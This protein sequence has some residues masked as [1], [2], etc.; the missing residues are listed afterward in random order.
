MNKCDFNACFT[1][2]SSLSDV[3]D[4]MTIPLNLL[5]APA[6]FYGEDI[7]ASDD[8]IHALKHANLIKEVPGKDKEA[9]VCIV[10][11]ENLYR[12]VSVKCLRLT[13][14]RKTYHEEL[15]EYIKEA[16]DVFAS[17]LILTTPC[18]FQNI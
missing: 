14:D 13:L 4:R 17:A 6:E 3:Q 1:T 9:F 8:M 18:P 15:T 2:A 12:R 11:G 16:I 10:E 7:G 5:N